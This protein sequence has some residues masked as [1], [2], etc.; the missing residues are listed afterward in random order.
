MVVIVRALL[1]SIVAGV[2]LN[3][4]ALPGP[5]GGDLWGPETVVKRHW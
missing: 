1:V 2:G 5:P 3:Y 4:H